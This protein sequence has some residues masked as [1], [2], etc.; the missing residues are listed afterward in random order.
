MEKAKPKGSLRVFAVLM[1]FVLS[2]GL[3]PMLAF[4]AQGGGSDSLVAG[5]TDVS[6]AAD[7]VDVYVTISKA[8][9]LVLAHE[10]VTVTDRDGNGTV[11]FDEAM[12]AAHDKYCKGGYASSGGWVSK[13]W[14]IETFNTGYANNDVILSSGVSEAV[15]AGD[16]LVAIILKDETNYSD[17]IAYFDRKTATVMVGETLKLNLKGT[18]VMNMTNTVKALPSVQVGT[19]ANGTFTAL[20]GKTTDSSGNVE[21]SFNKTGTY[22]VS[23]SGTIYDEAS[24]WNTTKMDCPISAPACIVKVTK[25]DAKAKV[26]KKKTIK[27][28]VLKKKSFKFTAIKLTTDGKKTFKVVKADK[29]K[30]LKFKAGKVTV[31]KGTKKGTY[32]I[33]VK[34]SA[35]AGKNYKKFKA[36]T[37]TIKVK[38]K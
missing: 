27:A 31:K 26:V 9:T 7:P 6:T 30:C 11:T 16:D 2:M 3:A 21:L 15:K 36:K 24:E 38:V 19:W 18:T 13:L 14:G 17:R 35:K 29:K 25:A 37:Y 10:A 22:V 33:K 5:S 12:Q 34:A 23:A 32:T 8:G 20:K 28:S 1:A 4:A